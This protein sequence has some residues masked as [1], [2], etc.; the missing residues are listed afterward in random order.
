MSYIVDLIERLLVTRETLGNFEFQIL[1]V[2]LQQP[3][4]AYGVIIR[5]QIKERTNRDVSVG[6]LYT[7]LD[8]LERKG[9]VS[10]WWGEPT[11]E[12]G[13]RR[14]RYYKIEAAGVEAINRSRDTLANFATPA[15]VGAQP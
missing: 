15:L 5:Q 6:A 8:R 10:S 4:N 3:Q 13:G 2:L 9:F 14:K 12:R 7:A 1:S 11:A